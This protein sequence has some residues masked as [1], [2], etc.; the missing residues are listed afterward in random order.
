MLKWCVQHKMC[1]GVQKKT[2]EGVA[3]ACMLLLT[4]QQPCEARDMIRKAGSKRL[5]MS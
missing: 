5:S 1:E 2:E 4:L 3:R